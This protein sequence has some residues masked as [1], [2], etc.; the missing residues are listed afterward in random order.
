MG[1]RAAPFTPPETTLTLYSWVSVMI[2][3][4]PPIEYNAQQVSLRSEKG[5]VN[6]WR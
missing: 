6:L 1:V 3:L 2:S 4:G 5:A